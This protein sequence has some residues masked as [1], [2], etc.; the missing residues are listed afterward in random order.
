[1][2]I[3]VTTRIYEGLFRLKTSLT[4]SHVLV[5]WRRL[6]TPWLHSKKS[7]LFYGI[8]LATPSVF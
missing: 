1:M 5:S 8:A 7:L 3:S 2:P 4:G 6:L